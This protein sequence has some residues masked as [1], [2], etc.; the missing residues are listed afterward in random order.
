MN[1]QQTKIL[2][3]FCLGKTSEFSK[4]EKFKSN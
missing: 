2:K 1:I 4:K 3:A